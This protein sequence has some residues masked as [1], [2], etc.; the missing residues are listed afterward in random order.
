MC[1][2]KRFHNCFSNL[3]QLL[4]EVIFLVCLLSCI[5]NN[6]PIF[7][8]S[9]ASENPIWDVRVRWMFLIREL[10]HWHND[11]SRKPIRNSRI[12]I[13]S[14]ASSMDFFCFQLASRILKVKWFSLDLF[15][16][17]QKSTFFFIHRL[18]NGKNTRGS[19]ES[20]R[21]SK[22]LRKKTNCLKVIFKLGRFV[23]FSNPILHLPI[24]EI[25]H[26]NVYKFMVP[27]SLCVWTCKLTLY[28]MHLLSVQTHTVNMQRRVCR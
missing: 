10:S 12:Y 19:K 5:F 7:Y 14:S 16:Y 15:S 13:N 22:M 1:Y 11:H 4:D 18:G 23:T 20:N 8:R 2:T 24:F 26:L 9:N 21:F 6:S 25:V 17:Y 28:C 27:I 3:L